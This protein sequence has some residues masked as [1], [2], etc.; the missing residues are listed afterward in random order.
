MLGS[1]GKLLL[2]SFILSVLFGLTVIFNSMLDLSFTSVVTE[3]K[4]SIVRDAAT[5]GNESYSPNPVDITEG[6][7]ITWINNDIV[8]HTVTSGSPIDSKNNGKIFDSGLLRPGNIFNYTFSDFKSSSPGI[9]NY[10]CKVHPSML[11]KIDLSK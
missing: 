5:L 11:G 1:F 3:N 9:I 2:L 7:M 10:F 8:I 6:D 4:V